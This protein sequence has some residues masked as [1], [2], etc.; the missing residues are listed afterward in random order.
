MPRRARGWIPDQPLTAGRLAWLAAYP[1]LRRR[2]APWWAGPLR[3]VT[4]R[5]QVGTRLANEMGSEVMTGRL[6]SY[7]IPVETVAGR[8]SHEEELALRAGGTLPAWFFDAVEEERK[9]Y[10][11]SRR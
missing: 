4:A 6:V 11:R 3:V 10:R 7:S 5:Q 2:S 9:K 8:L 1:E